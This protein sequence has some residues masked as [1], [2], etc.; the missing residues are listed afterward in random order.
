MKNVRKFLFQ[1]IIACV[2]LCT[3]C[4]NNPT[5]KSTESVSATFDGKIINTETEYAQEE[6]MMELIPDNPEILM[7]EGNQQKLIFEAGDQIQIQYTS[8]DVS[9]AVVDQD[10]V[11]SA[12]HFGYAEIKGTTENK[13][14][15]WKVTVLPDEFQAY[16][17][18]LINNDY[19]KYAAEDLSMFNTIDYAVFDVDG[20]GTYELLIQSEDYDYGEAGSTFLIFTYKDRKIKKIGVDTG[21]LL[22]YD[23]DAGVLVAT[24]N[25]DRHIGEVVAYRFEGH[26]K[27]FASESWSEY[28]WNLPD[29]TDGTDLYRKY[30]KY[31]V[32]QWSKVERLRNDYFISDQYIEN[33]LDQEFYTWENE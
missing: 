29:S 16:Y 24:V 11:V 5:K 9:I 32:L 33:Q 2:L 26:M 15:L 22:G 10:G 14:C 21:W 8:S 3:G 18:F 13:S 31:S 17:S 6:N 1:C 20:D 4:N 23:P 30:A 28:D 19:L 25:G 7:H 27:S 12:N